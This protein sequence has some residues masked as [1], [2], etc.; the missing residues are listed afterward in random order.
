M[1]HVL[2]LITFLPLAGSL[3]V[4]F[5]PKDKPQ[6]VRAVAA[7]ASG[8]AFIASLWLWFN[9][10][11]TTPDFQ[12][13]EKCPWIPAF[14]IQYFM[15]IDGLSLAM[16]V[17]TTLLTLLAVIS[18]FGIEERIKEYFFFFLLLETGMLGVFVSLDLF[19]FYVFW[20]LTLVPMY[21]LIGIWGGP[22]KEYAAIK[23]FLFTLFGSV[24]MLIALL[25]L[26]FNTAPNT[27][28][29]TEILKQSPMLAKSLQIWIFVGLYLGF[30]IKVPAFPFHTWL[31]LAHVEA[32][33]AVSVILAGVLLKMGTYGLMRF[34]F[35]LLPQATQALA[36]Y[37]AIIAAINIVYGAF[38][39]L[40]QTDIKRMIAYSSVN[41]MGYA[42]LGMSSL[43]VIGFSGAALQMIS[44]GI[45]TG[46]L[47]LLVG[48]IYDRAHTRDVNAFGGLATKLPVYSGFMT[49]ACFASLGLPLLSGFFSEF[50]CFL[51]AFQVAQYRYL[52]LISLLGI[53]ITAA[54]FLV[55]IKKV[56]LGQFN[57]KW[58]K[59]TDMN[60]RELIAVV[61]LC[62]LMV[63]FGILPALLLN[64][65]NASLSHLADQVKV[66]QP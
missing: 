31:P 5:I 24:F 20:E 25:S 51:G 12:F 57:V 33:T 14:N 52:T 2:S 41:H 46:A 9:Y 38:C 37:L 54:F 21:F 40:A 48:V 53:L 35:A 23:F 3:A 13:V 56:F 27:F 29:Y 42:L 58:E 7:M 63:L 34:S 22:K 62:V 55:M 39:S 15:G 28:D 61:P 8:A 59:L 6:T 19:L 45:I 30:A 18:S 10:N 4:L 1:Q 11:G 36:F 43:N 64:P 16:V 66:A 17:L 44:H 26:Y 50:L 65:M 32:P 49:L 60:A 47:F